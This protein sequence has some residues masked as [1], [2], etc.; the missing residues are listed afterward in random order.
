VLEDPVVIGEGEEMPEPRRAAYH[1]A[2]AVRRSCE[3]SR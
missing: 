1:A 2:T 3:R